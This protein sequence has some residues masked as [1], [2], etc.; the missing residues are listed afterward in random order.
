MTT[1]NEQAVGRF[2]N[3]GDLM[4]LQVFLPSHSQAFGNFKGD[5][6][7]IGRIIGKVSD[8]GLVDIILGLL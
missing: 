3:D 8:F 4:V 7:P 6:M 2:V 5:D 1:L